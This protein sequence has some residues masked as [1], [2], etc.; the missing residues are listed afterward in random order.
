VT[1]LLNNG[2][3][4]GYAYY[5]DSSIVTELTNGEIE[6]CAIVEP[7]EITYSYANTKIAFWDVNYHKGKTFFLFESSCTDWINYPILQGGTEVYSDEFYRIIEY[8]APIA[9]E[10]SR[11]AD[12]R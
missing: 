7:P 12:E 11:F 8:S 4:F 10:L 5:W 3:T 9:F 1:Y 6:V 2:Y